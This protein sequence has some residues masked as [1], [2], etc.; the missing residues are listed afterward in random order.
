MCFCALERLTAQLKDT[1]E[2][3]DLTL[4]SLLLL[5]LSVDQGHIES[6][7]KGG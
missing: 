3:L 7:F 1:I 4:Q 5:S 6:V 2:R